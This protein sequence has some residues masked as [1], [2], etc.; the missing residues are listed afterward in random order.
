[1]S[2]KSKPRAADYGT[3]LLTPEVLKTCMQAHFLE[4]A[5]RRFFLGIDWGR[6]KSHAALASFDVETDGV[7]HLH[8]VIELPAR[9]EGMNKNRDVFCGPFT[10]GTV[11]GRFVHANK[12]AKSHARSL[13]QAFNPPIQGLPPENRLLTAELDYEWFEKRI[14]AALGL[15]HEQIFGGPM[16]PKCPKCEG[17][18]VRRETKRGLMT[19]MEFWGCKSFPNCCATRT[20]EEVTGELPRLGEIIAEADARYVYL[21]ANGKLEQLI[22]GRQFTFTQLEDN[23]D[24]VV[25]NFIEPLSRAACLA[26]TL[27]LDKLLRPDQKLLDITSRVCKSLKDL[28]DDLVEEEDV[29]IVEALKKRLLGYRQYVKTVNF[30][31]NY[32][33]GPE[34]L[35]KKIK[36][37]A[38][39]GKKMA[40][41]MDSMHK[42]V[43]KMVDRMVDK[44]LDKAVQSGA[45]HKDC[46][47]IGKEFSATDKECTICKHKDQCQ[48]ITNGPVEPTPWALRELDRL[49]AVQEQQILEDQM[50]QKTQQFSPGYCKKC[51]H[52]N[53]CMCSRDKILVDGMPRH[54]VEE[55]LIEIYV[56]KGMG[57]QWAVR[58]MVK[59]MDDQKL[60]A[61]YLRLTC[62]HQSGFTNVTRKV[63]FELGY[64]VPLELKEGDEC[65]LIA[66]RHCH[67]VFPLPQ[68]VARRSK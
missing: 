40:R 25:Q 4:E 18:M 35:K 26:E 45:V 30:G 52:S 19:G 33:A 8:D 47:K 32:G 57:D 42:A 11:T 29:E 13:R 38:D 59:Q 9:P 1:M 15:T 12:P 5:N 60:R 50:K 51:G 2:D 28:D 48:L 63:A 62:K 3:P 31:K 34:L 10:H 54:K 27:E 21:Q 67:Q 6:E 22:Y 56:N 49:A 55:K 66:C 14:I 53:G 16:E 61:E 7:M 23:P 43:N 17:P 68:E 36:G 65:P 41:G 39:A 24:I 44:E 37:F 58:R 46:R 64:D 20:L